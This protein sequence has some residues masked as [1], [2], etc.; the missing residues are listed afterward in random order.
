MAKIPI[1]SKRRSLRVLLQRDAFPFSALIDDDVICFFALVAWVYICNQQAAQVR[2]ALT[3]QRKIQAPSLLQQMLREKPLTHSPLLFSV[4]FSLL[5]LARAD[6]VNKEL[7][8][9]TLYY[10]G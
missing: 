9:A 2:T 6:R 8:K 3:V 5:P 1:P 4:L 7:S 10:Y